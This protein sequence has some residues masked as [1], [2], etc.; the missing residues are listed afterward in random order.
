MS[1]AARTL[2]WLGGKAEVRRDGASI[3]DLRYW[4]HRLLGAK[5][6]WLADRLEG[7]DE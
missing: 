7:A 4:G 2:R 6:H 1:L 3:V 5:L